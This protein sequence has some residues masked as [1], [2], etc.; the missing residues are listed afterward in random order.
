LDTLYTLLKQSLGK[1]VNKKLSQISHNNIKL[2]SKDW[3]LWTST[4]P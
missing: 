1:L 3:G 2:D 4:T